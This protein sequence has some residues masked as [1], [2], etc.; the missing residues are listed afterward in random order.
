MK[1]KNVLFYFTN[2]D[3]KESLKLASVQRKMI[4]DW[5]LG[6]MMVPDW[7]L[8]KLMN[9]DWLLGEMMISNWLSRSKTHM[10]KWFKKLV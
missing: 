4:G 7:L 2:M 8:G 3:K 1:K 6:T 9:N 5:L 10:L